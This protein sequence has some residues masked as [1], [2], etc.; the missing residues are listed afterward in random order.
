MHLIENQ[1]FNVI[2]TKH[3]N[4]IMHDLKA[5]YTKVRTS[6]LSTAKHCFAYGE[7]HRFYPNPPKMSDLEVISLSITAECLEIDSENLLW[8]KLKKD[9]ADLFP[10]LTCRTRY[11][12]RRKQLSDVLQECLDALSDFIDVHRPSATLIVDSI[13]IPICSIVREKTSKVCREPGRDELLAAKSFNPI[14]K[15]Y[16]IGYKFHLICT[17]QGVYRDYMITPANVHDNIYLKSL[18]F[19]DTHLSGHNLLGDRA[20][21]GQAIQLQLFDELKLNIQVPYRRNQKDYKRYSNALKIK[22]KTIEVVFA[23]FCDEFRLRRNYAKRFEGLHVR[24][25]TK[26]AAKTFKQ[27][28][29]MKNGRPINQTKH[30]LVA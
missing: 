11:N 3:K 14:F 4:T 30:A 24:L 26:I 5:I 20:Y 23:Q 22:R 21:I 17:D 15:N 12:I 18:T 27:Y 10:N 29:N 7:N 2:T 8:S 16:Y 1:Y 19:Q 13:P 6:I 9:Y 28:W 25:Q